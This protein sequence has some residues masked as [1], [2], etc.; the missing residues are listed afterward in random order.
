M[1]QGVVARDNATCSCPWLKT[2]KHRY[3]PTCVIHCPCGLLIVIAYA[4]I[5]GIQKASLL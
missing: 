1:L 3:M 4:N 2:G 5:I